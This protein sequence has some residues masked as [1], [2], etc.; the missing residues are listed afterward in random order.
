MIPF[1]R[2]FLLLLRELQRKWGASYVINWST[3][4]S[5]IR[6]SVGD[7]SQSLRLHCCPEHGIRDCEAVGGKKKIH[8]PWLKYCSYRKKVTFYSHSWAFEC[9]SGLMTVWWH[10]EMLPLKDF[11]EHFK[12]VAHCVSGLTVNWLLLQMSLSFSNFVYS[13]AVACF[14][15][16]V[17]L[18]SVGLR[19]LSGL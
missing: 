5:S 8:W 14:F 9:F 1:S 4:V 10:S 12:R 15:G 19:R 6:N 7:Y 17:L 2:L 11:I 16:M 18:V 13:P 3:A